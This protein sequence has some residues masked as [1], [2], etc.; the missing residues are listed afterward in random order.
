MASEKGTVSRYAAPPKSKTWFLLWG[1][2]ECQ[3]LQHVGAGKAGGAD[4][5]ERWADLVRPVSGGQ[6]P[7]LSLCTNFW[8]E[9]SVLCQ[10]KSSVLLFSPDI[11]LVEARLSDVLS[12]L[13]REWQKSYFLHSP[14]PGFRHIHHS[15]FWLFPKTARIRW[16]GN[17][18][19]RSEL[20]YQARRH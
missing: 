14:I 20:C 17:T 6:R 1:E 10:S 9:V 13:L 12:T 3:L 16:A 19:A 2:S 8:S 5:H 11:C 7:F 15:A 4:T 18:E